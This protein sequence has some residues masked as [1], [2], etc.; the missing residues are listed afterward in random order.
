MTTPNKKTNQ[1]SE[2]RQVIT[3]VCKP[4][5]TTVTSTITTTTLVRTTFIHRGVV[6]QSIARLQRHEPSP[7]I[8]QS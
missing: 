1:A 7:C 5:T 6:Y 2:G 8:L 4:E 3:H